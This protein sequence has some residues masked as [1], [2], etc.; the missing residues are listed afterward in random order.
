MGNYVLEID[1]NQV[2]PSKVKA[3]CHGEPISC[4]KS[5]KSRNL[6][7]CLHDS[8]LLSIQERITHPSDQQAW[9]VTCK[10]LYML[11]SL[12][13]KHLSLRRLHIFPMLARRYP[14]LESLD[15]SGCAS[16]SNNGLRCI[17]LYMGSRLLSLNLSTVRTFSNQGLISLTEACSSLI[18]LDLSRCVQVR[19]D[20]IMA[21]S[22][23]STLESL[24]L[25]GCTEVSDAGLVLLAFNCRNLR[26]VSLKWCVGITDNAVLA[27]AAYCLK[28]EELDVSYTE[29]TNASISAVCKL[30]SLWKLNLAA[31]SRVDDQALRSL[32]SASR[33]LQ[34]L[35]ISR[36]PVITYEGVM[37]LANGGLPL[38]SLMMSYC[39]IVVDPMLQSF[40]KFKNLRTVRFDAC[41]M[42]TVEL[43]LIGKYCMNLE[44]LSLSKCKGIRDSGLS[45]AVMG[46][47]NLKSIDLTACREITDITLSSIA[48]SCKG[49]VN[50]KLESCNNFSEHGLQE[51]CKSCQSLE[52]LDVTDSSLNDAGLMSIANCKYLKTLKLGI[53]ENIHDS[54]LSCIASNCSY[55]RELDLYRSV[56]ITDKGVGAICSQCTNLTSLNMSYCTEITDASLFAVAYLRSLR[57]LELRG[58]TQLSCLGLFSI[59]T[60]CKSLMELD[61][62]R[63]TLLEECT[64]LVLAK[65]CKT[66][67]Q[68]D[69]SYC[70]GTDEGIAAL[71]K[72]PYMQNLKLVHVKGTSV[73]GF[74]NVLVAGEGLRKVKL[75]VHLKESLSPYVILQAEARGCK[76]RWMEKL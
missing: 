69:L 14:F 65:Y 35:D 31:C 63:C 76:L 46:C 74:S 36:C 72:G 38:R 50:L 27:I 55:I 42:S 48:Y 13:R 12:N 57:I 61:L 37:E 29:I 54:G 9:S 4:C 71:A 62:K 30:E 5:I 16:V 23:I 75:P 18:R 66:L 45:A 25:N 6:L 20:D 53:C 51:L 41:D 47:P 19:D 73:V 39:H 43:G 11:Y 40:G 67:K 17:S 7:D 44:E 3:F 59:A 32:K 26:S 60:K 70:S 10:R 64:P 21:I 22:R 56:G 52:H 15:L 8:I 33:S 49:L 58:C 1:T 2:P 28:L 34:T 24:M 68:V